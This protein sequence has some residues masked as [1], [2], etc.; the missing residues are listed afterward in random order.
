MRGLLCQP[1]QLVLRAFGGLGDAH[2]RHRHLR[3]V[4]EGF[5]AVM[6]RHC[7]GVDRG[8]Q[9]GRRDRHAEIDARAAFDGTVHRAEIREV[10]LHDLGAEPAQGVGTLVLPPDQGA[11][12]VA[13]GEQHC[14]EVAADGADGAGRSGHKDRAAVCGFHHHIAGLTLCSE[15]F[16]GVWSF[17]GQITRPRRSAS[18]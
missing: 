1:V 16:S 5:D 11:H 6:A 17:V 18:R 12:L 8:L 10:A 4:Y 3:H 2:L 15:S 13:L 7:G 9:I 14:G